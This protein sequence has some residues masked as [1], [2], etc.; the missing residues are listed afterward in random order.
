[1][2]K[3]NK[4]RYNAKGWGHC[5]HDLWKLALSNQHSAFRIH[6]KQDIQPNE[7]VM[8][9]CRPDTWNEKTSLKLGP[10]GRLKNRKRGFRP[11][12]HRSVELHFGLCFQ[13]RPMGG[14][15]VAEGRRQ[16]ATEID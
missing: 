5:A 8:T 15:V 7:P 9:L 12:G 10:I 2:T 16:R 13:Q 3:A 11:L 1:L 4:I 6:Q 14:G